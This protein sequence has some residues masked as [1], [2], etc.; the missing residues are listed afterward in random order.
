MRLWEE[1]RSRKELWLPTEI[2]KINSDFIFKRLKV[3]KSPLVAIPFRG[4]CKRF[5]KSEDKYVRIEN[6]FM[7][8][9]RFID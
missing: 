6:A 1:S 8:K 5:G 9:L 4:A 3:Q 7:N 2:R